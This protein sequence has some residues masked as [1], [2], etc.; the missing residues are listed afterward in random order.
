MASL[1]LCV[2]VG[3]G[4]RLS[5]GDPSDRHKKSYMF[6]AKKPGA[7]SRITTSLASEGGSLSPSQIDLIKI[8][9]TLMP[10]P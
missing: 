8:V 2:S 9:P 1:E 5:L 7:N 6:S 3:S 4:N 10:L